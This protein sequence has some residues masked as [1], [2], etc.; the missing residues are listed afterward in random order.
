MKDKLS[1]IFENKMTMRIIVGIAIVGIV[2]IGLSE[3]IVTEDEP[4]IKNEYVQDYADEIET[5]IEGIVKAI[6]GEDNPEVMV[7]LRSEE[8]Y[9][10]ATDTTENLEKES[11]SNYIIVENETGS[12]EG[13]IITTYSPEIQG[14]VVVSTYANSFTLK[15]DII[16]AVQT[17]LDL[18]SNKVCVVAKSN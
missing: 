14:V 8:R 5:E 17:A 2:L 6:T 11:E 10:Y 3:F 7:T 16:S 9:V 18:P 1:N 4:Q 13:M 12:E 15:E